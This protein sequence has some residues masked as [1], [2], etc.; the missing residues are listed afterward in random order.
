MKLML[1][2]AYLLALLM[3]YPVILVLTAIAFVVSFPVAF[4]MDLLKN[5]VG[6]SKEMNNERG[7]RKRQTS[8]PKT[9]SAQQ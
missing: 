9:L 2:R 8:V 7:N 5:G 3:V 4:Y 1:V 6:I